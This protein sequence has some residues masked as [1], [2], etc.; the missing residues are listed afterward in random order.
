MR[1][2]LQMPM[3][4]LFPKCKAKQDFNAWRFAESAARRKQNRPR[5]E[6]MHMKSIRPSSKTST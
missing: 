4:R 3:Q 5:K 6:N 2:E 1:R